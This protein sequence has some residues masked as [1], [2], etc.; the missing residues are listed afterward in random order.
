MTGLPEPLG[1]WETRDF[2]CFYGFSDPR[3]L[4]AGLWSMRH[5]DRPHDVC[6]AEF[7]L[8]DSP[9][10]VVLRYVRDDEGRLTDKIEDPAIQA[11][12]ELPPAY[13]LGVR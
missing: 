5:L 13:L 2:S 7:Y 8:V 6:R 1:V 4:G 12:D 10:A 11:L 3:L 9:F